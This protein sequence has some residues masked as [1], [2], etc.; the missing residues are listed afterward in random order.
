MSLFICLT[1]SIKKALTIL[2]SVNPQR[3]YL[4]LTSPWVSLAPYGLEI[5][6]VVTVSLE[7]AGDLSLGIPATVLPADLFKY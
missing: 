4:F 1:S 6:L 3:T 7:R 2:L 5:V